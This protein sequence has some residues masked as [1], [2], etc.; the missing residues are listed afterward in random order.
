LGYVH[1][2]DAVLERGY[3][4]DKKYS[5]YPADVIPMWIADTDF[6][7]PQPVVDALVRR[8]QRGFYAYTPVSRRLRLA[9]KKWQKERFDWDI[10]EDLVEYTP[11]V[12]SG[13]ICAVRALS[14]PGDGIV[15]QSPCY[16]PFDALAQHNDR[17][18]I[19]NEMVL[20]DGRYEIDFEDF[21]RKVKDP[22]VKLFILCNPHNPTGRVLDEEELKRL[23][24]LCRDNGVKVLSDEIHGDV[25][26]SGHRHIPF[27][28]VADGMG[29]DWVAFINPSKTF[30][31][32]GLRTAAFIAGT[33]ALKE[34][35][36]EEVV[37]NK[38]IGENVFGTLALCTA[39]EECGYYADQ[40]AVYLEENYRLAARRIRATGKL[41]CVN[42]EGTY[43][44]WVDC[45]KLGLEQKALVDFFV[46]KAKLGLNNG[47]TFGPGGTGFMRMNI[48]CPRAT[49]EKALDRLDA[50][51]KEM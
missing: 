16:P 4:D 38:A 39:Y 31:V 10:D 30:N 8:A 32:P 5:E 23:A 45:R 28:K 43:L 35:V 3:D 26:F 48:A 40:L 9:V 25:V 47:V 14:A 44:L 42:M 19:R 17:R 21:E 11:G 46:E 7:S 50:A 12:I 49:L 1:D 37:S 34:A 29:L 27:G 6:K 24:R 15:I 51:L 41:D 22:A 2:F 18:L 20:K 36:H 13:V 33:P